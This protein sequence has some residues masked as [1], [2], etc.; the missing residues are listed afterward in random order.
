L[1]LSVEMTSMAYNQDEQKLKK[2]HEA[3][4]RIL[5]ETGMKFHHPEVLEILEHINDEGKHC[6]L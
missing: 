2:I 3:S 1:E 6:M 4:M 5:E